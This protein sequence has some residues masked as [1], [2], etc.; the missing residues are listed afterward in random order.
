MQRQRALVGGG[1]RRLVR[2]RLAFV[3]HEPHSSRQSV[4]G[5][6]FADDDD[7]AVVTHLEFVV[8]QELRGGCFEQL[9]TT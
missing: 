8:L 6:I 1:R 2:Q 5:E 3:A 9:A 7:L 4:L